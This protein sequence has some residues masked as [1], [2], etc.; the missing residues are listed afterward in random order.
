MSV[1]DR[2]MS[3]SSFSIA[4]ELVKDP[5]VPWHVLP[6][7]PAW[8]KEDLQKSAMSYQDTGFSVFRGHLHH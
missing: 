6:S 7:V 8:Q 3:Y 1:T 2:T 5:N 4:N